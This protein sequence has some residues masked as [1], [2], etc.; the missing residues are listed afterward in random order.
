MESLEG[1]RAERC[2]QGCETPSH[3]VNNPLDKETRVA[4]HCQGTSHTARPGILCLHTYLLCL[5]RRKK[6]VTVTPSSHRQMFP[7]NDGTGSCGSLF[8][9]P[10]NA[11]CSVTNLVKK[12]NWHLA[13]CYGQQLS[14]NWWLR[15]VET[16]SLNEWSSCDAETGEETWALHDF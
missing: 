3:G 1:V 14:D 11:R 7:S 4:C 16:H 5:G 2:S 8:A 13:S 10:G 6:L 15:E 12:F 9:M